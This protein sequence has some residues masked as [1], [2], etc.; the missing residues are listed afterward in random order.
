MSGSTFLLFAGM[1]FLLALALG[2][3]GRPAPPPP[4]EP[5]EEIHRW[6]VFR[7]DPRRLLTG[8]GPVLW[9]LPGGLQIFASGPFD[10]ERR[11][12]RLLEPESEKVIEIRA[13]RRFGRASVRVFLERK[14]LAD[15]RAPRTPR[16]LPE[17]D[18]REPG[19]RLSGSGP[20]MEIELRRDR[21]LL[22]TVSPSIAPGPGT[23][24]VEVLS[25]ED[26][27]P[28]LALVAGL[29]LLKTFEGS[30]MAAQPRPAPAPAGRAGSP[31]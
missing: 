12:V 4:V 7:F 6:S 20:A 14:P 19:L 5:P 22:A 1:A 23:I 9:K 15:L 29:G 30:E 27:L 13:R 11:T 8:E 10:L 31:A 3:M 26:P 16:G 24:G 2:M 18:A 25:A 28:A 17:I 21:Q